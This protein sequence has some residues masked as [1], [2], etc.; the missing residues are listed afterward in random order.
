[1]LYSRVGHANMEL[2]KKKRKKNIYIYIYIIF[3][4]D[5]FSLKHGTHI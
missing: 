1:M 4:K 5:K 2:K 3:S